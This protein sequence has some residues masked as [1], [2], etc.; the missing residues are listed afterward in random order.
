[1]DQSLKNTHENEYIFMNKYVYSKDL[2]FILYI[3]ISGYLYVL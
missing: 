1:M 3:K 2:Q